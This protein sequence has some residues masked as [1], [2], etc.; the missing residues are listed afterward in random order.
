[1]KKITL[2]IITLITI[3]IVSCKKD[4]TCTCTDATGSEVRKY[5][6]VT[7]AQAKA[8][9]QTVQ[10]TEAGATSNETCTLSK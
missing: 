4:R 6:K 3:S 2:I 8:D 5:T 10:H 9:C 1:M 7:K